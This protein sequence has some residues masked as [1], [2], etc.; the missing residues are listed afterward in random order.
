MSHSLSDPAG[1]AEVTRSL[2][3]E[4]APVRMELP[5]DT[6]LKDQEA[7]VA[8]AGI[9]GG[10][11]FLLLS[12]LLAQGSFFLCFTKHTTPV[13]SP[14]SLLCVLTLLHPS[15]FHRGSSELRQHS[16]PISLNLIPPAHSLMRG[17]FC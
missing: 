10:I 2:A 16:L 11:L 3:M 9:E 7:S 6:A 13:S 17:N 4:T 12:S 8:S 15:L 14:L 5:S 1:V